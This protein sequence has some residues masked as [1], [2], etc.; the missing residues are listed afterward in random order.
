M[1][2]KPYPNLLEIWGVTWTKVGKVGGS[3]ATTDPENPML[4][5]AVKYERIIRKD[6]HYVLVNPSITLNRFGCDEDAAA[7][8]TLT[9]TDGTVIPL[10]DPEA[11]EE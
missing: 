2:R 1:S 6:G 8:I 5:T 4:G 10:G 7:G 9:R 11:E 3:P